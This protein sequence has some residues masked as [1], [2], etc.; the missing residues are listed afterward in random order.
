MKGEGACPYTD[1]YLPSLTQV[2]TKEFVTDNALGWK[3]V[4]NVSLMETLKT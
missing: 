4:T 1:K 2:A 3:V